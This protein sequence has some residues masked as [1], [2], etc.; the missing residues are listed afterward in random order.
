MTNYNFKMSRHK[1][2]STKHQLETKQEK[3]AREKLETL[4]MPWNDI[5]DMPDEY[6]YADIVT[7]FYEGKKMHRLEIEWMLDM[8]KEKALIVDLIKRK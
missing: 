5:K 7:R 6:I 8:I 2:Q 3:R 1:R 4:Y